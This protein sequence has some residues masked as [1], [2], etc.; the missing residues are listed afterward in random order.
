MIDIESIVVSRRATLSTTSS[1]S[2]DDSPSIVRRR[3]FVVESIERRRRDVDAITSSIVQ[4][5]EMKSM[6]KIN[7]E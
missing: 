2:V 3:S 6:K 1:L 7:R 4:E 5:E